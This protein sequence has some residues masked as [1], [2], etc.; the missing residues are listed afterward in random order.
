MW[1]LSKATSSASKKWKER[2][3][4]LPSQKLSHPSLPRIKMWGY[5]P[6][7]LPHRMPLLTLVLV[8]VPPFGYS[9][10]DVCGGGCGFT[11]AISGGSSHESEN[12]PKEN[13]LMLWLTSG[14]GCSA[15]SGLVIEIDFFNW[16][17]VKV[18]YCDGA[19]FSGDSQNEVETVA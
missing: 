11:M 4:R 13:P 17:R 15:F 12:N 5:L 6:R 1:S 18:R 14:P 19:S 7:A 9:W 2:R 16:N 3:L 8:R 10:K